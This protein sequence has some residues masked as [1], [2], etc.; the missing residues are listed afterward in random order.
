LARGF[1]TYV[2][3]VV[4]F[5]CTDQSKYQHRA[6]RSGRRNDMGYSLT[7]L[8][9]D[10][11]KTYIN[12]INQ[13]LKT[14]PL[15]RARDK[16]LHKLASLAA[17]VVEAA[18][19]AKKDVTT[20]AADPMPIT[21]SFSEIKASLAGTAVG[22]SSDAD[23][24]SICAYVE[25]VLPG[26]LDGHIEAHLRKLGKKKD[27]AHLK[28]VAL[29]HADVVKAVET[30]KLLQTSTDTITRSTPDSRIC[31]PVIAECLNRLKFE[32]I[33]SDLNKP[34]LSEL[35]RKTLEK[36]R[37]DL[38][39][40]PRMEAPPEFDKAIATVDSDTGLNKS[41]SV[42]YKSTYGA[43]KSLRIW[44]DAELWEAMRQRFIGFGYANP[45]KIEL[46]K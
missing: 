24:K 25:K 22:G 32:Q 1:D 44:K 23:V 3:L 43:Y 33:E 10:E 4:Q 26:L 16:L 14:R 17:C 2:T 29:L 18:G 8:G 34:G 37:L 27:V 45:P 46:K 36:S 21:P 11:N 41:R 9:A 40:L 20:A 13:M 28:E 38:S 7:L 12:D 6:G 19:T 31:G 42:A 15:L 30:V 35:D 39:K 5:G